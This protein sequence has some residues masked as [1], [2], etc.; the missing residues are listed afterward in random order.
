MKMSKKRLERPNMDVIA[1]D[2]GDII[3]TSS[4]SSG[5]ESSTE[6]YRDKPIKHCAAVLNVCSKRRRKPFTEQWMVRAS[7]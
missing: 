1:F 2:T 5:D 3:T 7:K 4:T 6:N